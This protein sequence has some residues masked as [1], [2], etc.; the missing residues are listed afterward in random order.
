MSLVNGMDGESIHGIGLK[1]NNGSR[2][3]AKSGK[4]MG[5]SGNRMA[6]SNGKAM[7][8]IGNKVAGK[9]GQHR[10]VIGNTMAGKNNKAMRLTQCLLLQLQ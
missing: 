3:T 1:T 5:R 9:S 7:T 4:A 6:G 10:T 2:K 8:V